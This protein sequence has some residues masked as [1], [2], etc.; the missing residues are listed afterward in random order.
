MAVF[1]FFP[2]SMSFPEEWECA[3]NFNGELDIVSG[4]TRIVL[5][6]DRHVILR[7]FTKKLAEIQNAGLGEHRIRALNDKL[8]LQ[9]QELRAFEERIKQL[10]GQDYSRLGFRMYDSQGYQLPGS[11]DYRYFGAAKDLPGVRE[12]FQRDVPAAPRKEKAKLYKNVGADYYGDNLYSEELLKQ[13]EEEEKAAQEAKIR[14][15]LL[16]NRNILDIP[17]TI[18]LKESPIEEIQRAL[19]GQKLTKPAHV[20]EEMEKRSRV[21]D[22]VEEKQREELER[23]KKELI[24]SLVPMETEDTSRFDME[25]LIRENQNLEDVI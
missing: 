6:K 24:E 16:E 5:M 4:S 2:K 17:E 18:S 20:E 9:L 13:E 25:T 3:L 22:V 23:R 19:E 7:Y 15:W 8:N 12:L 1:V 11:G 10:G 21:E 14:S